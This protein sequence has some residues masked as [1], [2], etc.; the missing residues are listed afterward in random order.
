[1]GLVRWL[2]RKLEE[3]LESVRLDW[4]NEVIGGAL[5]GLLATILLA[6]VLGLVDRADLLPPKAKKDSMTWPLLQTVP[7]QARVAYE[8]L[9]PVVID[10]WTDSKKALDQERQSTEPQ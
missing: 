4:V 9:E 10:F 7:E 6:S 5:Y 1:M 3:F 2:S 8:K